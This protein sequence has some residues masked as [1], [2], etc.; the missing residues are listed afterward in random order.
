MAETKMA[1]EQAADETEHLRQKVSQLEQELVQARL[2]GHRNRDHAFRL[3]ADAAPVMIW[4]I[5]S[6]GLCTFCNKAWLEFRGRSAEEER[7][8]GWTAGPTS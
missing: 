8:T 6:D 5:G 2:D 4:L 1:P 3:L 7:G